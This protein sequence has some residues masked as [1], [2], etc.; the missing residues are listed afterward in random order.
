[1]ESA[2]LSNHELTNNEDSYSGTINSQ[3]SGPKLNLINQKLS[4]EPR[5]SNMRNNQNKRVRQIEVKFEQA[6][7]S[8]QPDSAGLPA[9]T[10]SDSKRETLMNRN[11]KK[12][13][14]KKRSCSDSRQRR[15][16]KN[17]QS[18]KDSRKR[19]KEYI[20]KIEQQVESLQLENKR[21]KTLNANLK[22]RQKLQNYS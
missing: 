22:E 4:S 1:M 16:E 19:K 5:K 21:L 9:K 14:G 7:V 12:G 20:E 10:D 11:T 3:G 15:L 2:K 17:R 18:A 8:D 13:P 6:F